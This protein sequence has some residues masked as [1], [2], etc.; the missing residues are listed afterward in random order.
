MILAG[1]VAAGIMVARAAGR[2]TPTY[3][4][5]GS[6]LCLGVLIFIALGRMG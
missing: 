5:Y 4:A 3:I 1:I 2:P 6:Y